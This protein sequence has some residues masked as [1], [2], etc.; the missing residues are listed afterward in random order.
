MLLLPVIAL[1]EWGTV[2]GDAL[3]EYFVLLGGVFA[4]NIFLYIKRKRFTKGS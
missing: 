1:M 3:T 4:L 2:G